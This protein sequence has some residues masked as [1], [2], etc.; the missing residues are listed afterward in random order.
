MPP[1]PVPR[2]RPLHS[3]GNHISKV[4]LDLL[5]VGMESATRHKSAATTWLGRAQVGSL[6][7]NVRLVPAETYSRTSRVL[8]WM[9]FSGVNDR[10][11]SWKSALVWYAMNKHIVMHVTRPRPRAMSLHKKRLSWCFRRFDTIKGQ[12]TLFI[13]W[14]NF[15][16]WMISRWPMI[17]RTLSCTWFLPHESPRVAILWSN[18][19]LTCMRSRD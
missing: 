17:E 3:V 16:D 18:H 11:R 6:Y 1:F 10:H 8:L 13:S 4:M 2:N 9:Y 19:H 14:Y 7:G 5:D 12:V 15:R